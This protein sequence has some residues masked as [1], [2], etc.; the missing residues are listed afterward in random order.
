MFLSRH[1]ILDVHSD[2]G[3]RAVLPPGAKWRPDGAV[4]MF[5]NAFRD[6]EAFDAAGNA[7]LRLLSDSFAKD[8]RLKALFVYDPDRRVTIIRVLEDK[9]R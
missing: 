3:A 8:V 1:E 6:A 5:M 9:R 2:A 7:V 4:E